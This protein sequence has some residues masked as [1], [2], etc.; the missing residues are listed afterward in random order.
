MRARALTKDLQAQAQAGDSSQYETGDQRRRNHNDYLLKQFNQVKAGE[1]RYVSPDVFDVV[2]AKKSYFSEVFCSTRD[3]VTFIPTKGEQMLQAQARTAYVNLQLEKNRF[4]DI[5]RDGWHD[6]FVA[7]RMVVLSEWREQEAST[8]IRVTGAKAQDIDGLLPQDTI[9]VDTSGLK[10]MPNGT[11]AG[12][13][14]AIQDDSYVALTLMQ[15]ERYYRDPSRD[16]V[17]DSA[18]AGFWWEPTRAELIADGFNEELVMGLRG[19]N[20]VNRGSDEDDARRVSGRNVRQRI[21]QNRNT[22][23]VVVNR[24]WSTLRLADY[25]EI[26]DELGEAA[27]SWDINGFALYEVWW[28]GSDIL[29][30][31]DGSLCIYLDD[32]MPFHE[33]SEFKIPHTDESLCAAD[34][35]SPTQRVNSTLKRLIVNNQVRRNTTRF[36]AVHGAVKNPRELLDNNIGGIVWSKR[37]GS[38]QALESPELSPMTFSVLEMLDRDKE[39][40][41]GVSRLAK[42]M[43]SDAIRYQNAADMIERLTNASNKRDMRACRDF[44]STFLVPLA[45]RIYRLGVQNDRKTHN[46][47]IDGAY[48]AITPGKWLDRDYPMQIAAALTPEENERMAQTLLSLHGILKDDPVLGVLYGLE[49]RHALVNDALNSLGIA[50]TARYMRRPNDPQVAQAMQAQAAQAEQQARL[51]ADQLAFNKWMVQSSEGRL[52]EMVNIERGK[53]QIDATDKAAD[54][55]RADEKLDHEKVVDMSKLIMEKANIS[56]ARREAEADDTVAQSGN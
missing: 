29:E 49:Q 27:A 39:S 7:K 33:W 31:A 42:G 55:M 47:E 40:R 11:Y 56:K 3:V 48:V 10:P 9:R 12:S 44:A 2:E 36:E 37:I 19:G 22:E 16:Y 28:S 51:A 1:S 26:I 18:Y 45:R 6:A 25:P 34:V 35:V 14:V 5:L 17:K 50:S 15:P 4:S 24:T 20:A 21:D 52:W 53:M 41:S 46:V 54:N 23:T 13:A 43:N 32:E 8:E 30:K 38:V